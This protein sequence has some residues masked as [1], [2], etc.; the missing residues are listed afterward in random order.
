M[1]IA[2]LGTGSVGQHLARGFIALGHDVLVGTR[3]PRG[4]SAQAAVDAIG[5]PVR[6]AAFAEAAQWCEIALLATLWEG[7]RS[8]L[9][10]AGAVNLAGKLVVD[11]TNPLDFSQGPA[12][13]LGFDRSGGEL[14]QGWLPRA[15]VVKAFNTVTA[16]LMYQPKLPGGPPTMF[17]AGNDAAAKQTVA[18]L[19]AQFGWEAVDIGGIDGA[20]LLEPLAMLYIRHAIRAKDW[21]IA[22]KL[23]RASG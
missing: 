8:A 13:A 4:K 19:L 15:N 1:N 6:A 3:D 18:G 9:E 12:L 23:L 11:V 16:P 10:L 20:R 22:F 7:T 5:P 17:I 2:V 14:V 21:Q